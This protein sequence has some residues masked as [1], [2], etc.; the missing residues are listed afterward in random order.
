MKNMKKKICAAL[1]ILMLA[2][3][4][5]YGATSEDMSVYVR[6]DVFDAMM[7]AFMSEIRLM[8]EQLR[9][10]IRA[11]GARIDGVETSL[12]ARI[13]G[14]ETS[15]NARMDKVETSLNARIDGVERRMST[16]ETMIYWILATLSAALAALALTPY[17][18]EL[19]KPSITLEDVSKL[20]EENNVKLLKS[21]QA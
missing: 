10:E 4:V 1:V 13:D 19:R 6:I 8:N 21:L 18:K 15:L 7:D 14:V 12:N 3:T 11:L 20:I 16:L 9:G 17:M 2:C 5:C